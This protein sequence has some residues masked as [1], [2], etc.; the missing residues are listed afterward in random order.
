MERQSRC[1]AAYWQL[2][3]VFLR[4]GGRCVCFERRS[5]RYAE[6]HP[7]LYRAH[8][9]AFSSCSCRGCGS[10]VSSKHR[11]VPVHHLMSTFD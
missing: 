9:Y 5:I 2:P 7:Y 8:C 4:S 6:L 11:G 3:P 1:D 10:F